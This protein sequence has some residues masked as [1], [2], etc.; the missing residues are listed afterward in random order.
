MST[1][2]LSRVLAIVCLCAVTVL[3]WSVSASPVS[4]A[5]GNVTLD[6]LVAYTS[7]AQLPFRS[8]PVTAGDP[9]DDFKW[10]I[11]EDNIGDVAFDPSRC[12]PTSAQDANTPLAG[13]SSLLRT[14]GPP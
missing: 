10:L 7:P 2:L 9:I 3:D 12:L 4:A 1:K 6:V 14:A 11:N 13:S 8:F 5:G